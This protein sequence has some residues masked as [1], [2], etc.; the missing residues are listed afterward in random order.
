VEGK[1]RSTDAYDR[2]RRVL[3]IVSEKTVLRPVDVNRKPKEVKYPTYFVTWFIFG[4]AA[5]K[6]RRVGGGA[7]RLEYREQILG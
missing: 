1:V 5:E 4:T 3:V 7:P 2:K 6:T